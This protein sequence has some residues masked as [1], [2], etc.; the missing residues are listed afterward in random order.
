[1][2]A[3]PGGDLS[4]LELCTR[5]QSISHI[6]LNGQRNPG[7]SFRRHCWLRDGRFGR[8]DDRWGHIG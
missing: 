5:P 4:H 6:D 7:M 1:M 2:H 3:D 8:L